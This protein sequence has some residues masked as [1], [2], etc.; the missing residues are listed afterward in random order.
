M[1]K[2]TRKKIPRGVELTPD[3][4]FEPIEDMKDEIVSSNIDADQRKKKYS[5]F[6]LNFNIPWLDSKYFFDNRVDGD[7]QND[8]KI[9][10]PFYI[11]F[12]LPP[13]QEAF[14]GSDP[15]ITK[16]V[17]IPIL[18]SVG[19]SFDQSDEPAAVL[20]KWYGKT[21]VP[22]GTPADY[23][24]PGASV[25]NGYQIALFNGTQGN[26]TTGGTT[27]YPSTAQTPRVYVPPP[28][29]GFKNYI[30]TD[31]Y[32][33]ELSI[34]E[35][36]QAFFSKNKVTDQQAEDLRQPTGELLSL[37]FP[38]TNYIAKNDRRN[39]LTYEGI[40]KEI[41]P[42]KTYV[43]CL[44]APNL[45]DKDATRRE[46]CAIVNLWITLKFKLEL[47]DRDTGTDIQNIPAHLGAKGSP[48][49]TVTKPTAGN[50]IVGDTSVGSGIASGVGLEAIDKQVRNK[51]RGG[52]GEFSMTHQAEAVK[53]DAAYEVITV[54]LGQGFA[55]NRMSVRDD[56]LF[57]PYARGPVYSGLSAGVN[58]LVQD[59]YVDRRIIPITHP[60]TIHHVVFAMNYTSDRIVKAYDPTHF[61]G[62]RSAWMN[63]TEPNDTVRYEVGV[64]MVSGV[65]GDGFN[66]AQVAYSSW[67][68]NGSAQISDGQIDAISLGLPAVDPSAS[69]YKLWSVPIVTRTGSVGSGYWSEYA[70]VGKGNNGTPYYIGE[71]NTYTHERTT[72]GGIG[73]AVGTYAFSGV[74]GPSNGTEQYLE[75]RFLVDPT[76][77]SANNPYRYDAA[78]PA[79]SQVLWDPAGAGG[80]H[81]ETD[82]AIGYGGCWLYI[83]GKKHVT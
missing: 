60:M 6:R 31:A 42:Y 44:K 65:R 26:P 61:E 48:S 83:I 45:H 21:H 16:G 52:Y 64:G 57:S 36:E 53:Q 54:P 2:V 72:I 34:L 22:D 50:L 29:M 71:A 49:V 30:R 79:G 55:F 4:A 82:L 56:Y 37:A 32:D 78:A 68:N 10:A 12:C 46:H 74:A 63:M 59:P 7:D 23:A 66:Y 17:P 76:N 33:L 40:N 81:R 77:N 19:L 20:G 67:V 8:Y 43:M 62:G 39:P 51:L 28:F 75:V 38:G 11:P 58:D 5:T 47:V 18:T 27:E 70:A 69:E 80:T 41:N 3:H 25:H 15:R 1:A 73:G 35:K 9:D 24:V 13:L 14:D